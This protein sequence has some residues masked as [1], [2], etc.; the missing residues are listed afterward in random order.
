MKIVL[1]SIV[2]V[3]LLIVSL[4]YKEGFE[5]GQYAYLAPNPVLVVDEPTKN[6]FITVGKKTAALLFPEITVTDDKI[7]QL[8]NELNK[9]TDL[10]LDEINYYIQ[11]N[12]WPYGPYIMNYLTVNKEDVLNKLK[13][14]KTKTLEDLQ[15]VFPTRF[16]YRYLI[17]PTETQISPLPLSNDIFMGRKEAPVEAAKEPEKEPEKTIRPSF[18]SDN[19]TKLQSICSTLK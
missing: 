12:K 11:N 4:S 5:S 1:Y 10:S 16:I 14:T 9:T 7:T 13:N 2:L 3:V 17:A 8:K 15:K 6:N 19:Y 18:S